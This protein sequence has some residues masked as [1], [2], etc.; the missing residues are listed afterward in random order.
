[1]PQ[2]CLPPCGLGV[3]FNF[4]DELINPAERLVRS[5]GEVGAIDMAPPSGATTAKVTLSGMVTGPTVTVP[6]S[7]LT[8]LM[9]AS[10]LGLTTRRGCDLAGSGSFGAATATNPAP[11]A[12][13]EAF[14]RRSLRG[15]ARWGACLLRVGGARS[16]TPQR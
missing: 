2:Y 12:V 9:V 10:A 13:P 8:R 1:M 15:L 5:L 16:A 14:L 4:L 11:V 7:S 6:P 3:Q